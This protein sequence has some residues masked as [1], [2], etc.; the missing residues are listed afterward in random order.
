[1]RNFDFA[2]GARFHGFM[3]AIQAGMPGGVIAHDSRTLE[4]CETMQIPDRK[5]DELPQSLDLCAI[6]SLFTFDVAAYDGAR[7]RLGRNCV[8][9]LTA[10][11]IEPGQGLRG[12]LRDAATAEQA[13]PALAAVA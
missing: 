13:S 12:L 11:E 3:L 4:M 7:S 6:S 10:A 9:M 5:F 8:E 2:D 1:M